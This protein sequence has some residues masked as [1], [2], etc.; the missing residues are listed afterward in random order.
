MEFFLYAFYGGVLIAALIM[1]FNSQSVLS[2]FS[3]IICFLCVSAI[4]I[5]LS[6]EVL[7]MILIIVY[8]GAIAVLFLFVTMMVDNASL[9]NNIVSFKRTVV[10]FC[11]SSLFFVEVY[12]YATNFKVTLFGDIISHMSFYDMSIRMFSN[13]LLEIVM[14][15]VLLLLA[16]VVVISLSGTENNTIKQQNSV[17]QVLLTHSKDR[18]KIVK[19]QSGDGVKY[20]NN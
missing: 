15:G 12:I 8:V 18:L 20:D 17:Q 1:L 13:Y 2:V 9:S 10:A 3:L 11:L 6:A 14:A 4:F 7:A 16:M 19:V 5:I